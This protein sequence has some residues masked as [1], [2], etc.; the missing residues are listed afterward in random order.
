MAINLMVC[1][2]WMR[3]ILRI[4][5]YSVMSSCAETNLETKKWMREWEAMT[6]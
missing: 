5:D 4:E 3:N 1:C 6:S 2:M